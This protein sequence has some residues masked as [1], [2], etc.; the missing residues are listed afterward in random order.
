MKKKYTKNVIQC[1][2][3]DDTLLKLNRLIAIDAFE[4]GEKPKGKSEWLRLL[5]EDTVNF[6]PTLNKI[7]NYKP[8]HK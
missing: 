5:I 3:D 2:I 8:N 4:N 7:K 6:E 1:L